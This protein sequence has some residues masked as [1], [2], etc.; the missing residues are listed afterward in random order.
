[1][2][3]VRALLLVAISALVLGGCGAGE[4]TAPTVVAAFYPLAWAAENVARPGQE[5]LDLTPP[6]AEPH[7][8]EISP[9]DVE[10]IRAARLV[11]YVGGGFQP[12]VE[13][14]VAGRDGPSLDLLGGEGDPHVWLDPARFADAV[15][16]LGRALA[17]PAAGRRLADRLRRL[18]RE[19]AAGLERCERRVLVTSHAAF[20][21]LADRYRLA[22]VSLAGLSP[23]AEPGPQA[24]ERLVEEV[25]SSGASTVFTEPLVSDRLARTVAR[26]AGV[27]VS[28]LDPV[29]GLSE[30]R[31][32]TGEDYLT[33]MRDNLAVLRE[34]LG[35]R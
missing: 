32:E 2:A 30:E 20:G 28:V 19:Y 24:I 29:E 10:A 3:R 18:D 11:V 7:D 6:G 31:V 26:E 13:D 12:A 14:A 9:R 16:Q 27:G 22:H 4:T 34:A 1:V 17:R 25:R 33:V 21:R 23:E 8:V 5:V 15:A 35:C